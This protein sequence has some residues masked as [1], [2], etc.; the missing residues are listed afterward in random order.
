MRYKYN[1]NEQNEHGLHFEEMSKQNTIT[2]QGGFSFIFFL[3][4]IF[5]GKGVCGLVGRSREVGCEKYDKS[6]KN[7]RSKH[8]LLACFR[9]SASHCSTAVSSVSSPDSTQIAMPCI[10]H[11]KRGEE[12]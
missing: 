2:V 4:S 7:N 6:W 12:C 3:L 1:R 9:S 8:P 10:T 11:Y 5:W